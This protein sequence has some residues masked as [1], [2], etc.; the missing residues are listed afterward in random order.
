MMNTVDTAKNL[1]KSYVKQAVA[2]K[3]AT[4]IL[5]N[6]I[7]LVILGI[8]LLLICFT[9][10]ATF[11]L[12]NAQ[13]EQSNT[14]QLTEIQSAP[15][16]ADFSGGHAN[17]SKVI[18]SYEPLIREEAKKNG[19][20]Q[21]TELLLALTQN[22]AGAN[23]SVSDIMQA[24][25]SQGWG[26][27]SISDPALS[28]QIGVKVFADRLKMSNNDPRLALQTYNFGEA[29]AGWVK[30]KN[31]GHY[32]EELAIEFSKQ[33]STGQYSCAGRDPNN[34]RTKMGACYGD[35]KYVEKVTKLFS[36]GG[37][38][39]D[40]GKIV[41]GNQIFD[42]NQ[43]HNIMKQFLGQPYVWG[44]RTPASG[45]DC[46]GLME[47]SFAQVGININGNAHM[48]YNK[49]VAVPQGQEQPG[50]LVF[51]ETYKKAPSHVG[52]YMG[53]DQFINS[54]SKGIQ[55]SSVNKWSNKY[56]FLG[57]RRIVKK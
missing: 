10:L 35:Y 41:Q 6:P 43:V 5:S 44:G 48:Q 27:N 4:V 2:K 7:L 13:D 28:I 45:F 30:K 46:S 52:M 12:L 31:G 9:G 47:W 14:T 17:V 34:Y 16:N 53:N 18:R 19:I 38:K 50:D 26:R 54:N 23:P 49:T 40:F 20:E 33:Y 56:K 25:E 11:Y 3:V 21:Y 1:A 36:G 42:V 24:S 57:Y 37:G 32:T 39:T 22:E 51:W 55:Y 29:F 8:I 15:L